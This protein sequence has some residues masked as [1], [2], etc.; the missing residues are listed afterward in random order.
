[1]IRKVKRQTTNSEKIVFLYKTDN[2]YQ[3]LQRTTN[4]NK[5]SSIEN[6]HRT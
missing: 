6:W 1:M 5:N 4:K 2:G 3:Y